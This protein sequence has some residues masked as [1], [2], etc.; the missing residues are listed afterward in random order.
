MYFHVINRVSGIQ[1]GN[2]PDHMIR[3]QIPYSTVPMTAARWRAG[4]TVSLCA[5]GHHA[6]YERSLVQM[7]FGS[8]DER[9]RES[10]SAS[11]GCR[12]AQLYTANLGDNL[13]VGDVP[14]S[15]HAK[16]ELDDVVCT[17]S[18]AAWRVDG[19]L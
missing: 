4:H 6:H 14:W 1:N 5:S 3:A 15:Y 11:G 7:G 19:A 13:P 8:N 10:S 18:V 2:V 9:R 12:R 17:F 16:P